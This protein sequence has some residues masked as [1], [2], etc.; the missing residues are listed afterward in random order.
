M[1]SLAALAGRDFETCRDS[2]LAVA[3]LAA[4]SLAA[5]AGLGQPLSAAGGRRRLT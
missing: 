4:G 2:K 5:H 3:A 1:M